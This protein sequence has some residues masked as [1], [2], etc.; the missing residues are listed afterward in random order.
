[1]RRAYAFFV[2]LLFCGAELPLAAQIG[3]PGQY[4][5][6]GRYPGGGY[7]PG[8]GAGTGI[9][10]PRRGKKT[11]SKDKDQPA[12]TKEIEG[13]LR[14]MDDKL[15]V[16]E[17]SDARIISIKRSSTTKFLKQ[18]EAMKPADLK[19]GDHLKIDVTEDEQGF[20]YAV[21]VNFD[22]AGTAAERARAAE[23]VE[24]IMPKSSDDDDRPVQKRAGSSAKASRDPDDPDRPVQKRAEPAAETAKVQPP[25]GAEPPAKTE[26]SKE[27]AAPKP[28]PAAKPAAKAPAAP[29]PPSDE[30]PALDTILKAPKPDTPTPR[31]T[32]DPGPPKLGR[33]RP[34]RRSTTP[35]TE[36]QQ[37]VQTATTRPPAPPVAKDAP[38][39][40]PDRNVEIARPSL[41]QQRAPQGE[42]HHDPVIEKA[43]EKAGEFTETLPSY[44]CQEMMARFYNVSHTVNWQPQDVVSMEVVYDQGKE[45]YRNIAVN[46][47]PSKKSMQELG[48]AWS[49]GEFGT[50]LIDLFSPATAADFRYRRGSVTAGKSTLVYD[51]DVQQP[52]SHWNIIGAAQSYKPAYRGTVWIDKQT[53]R[54]LRIE[55]QAYHFPEDFPFDKVES[56]T[57]YDYVRFAA[58]QQ[59]LMPVHAETLMCSRGTNQCSMNKID[60]RNYHK[61]AGESVISFGDAKEVPKDGAADATKDASKTKSTKKR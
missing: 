37:P 21:N 60:F 28:A 24:V 35:D 32:D 34:V 33:G 14:R 17:A 42:A 4:P 53:Y 18:D 8:G 22:K 2:F 44:V 7:P 41:P 16:L 13:M 23:P 27:T 12:P 20:F 52:N 29:E 3:Y 6:G 58:D 50:V 51:F 15:I 54:V 26:P 57:D 5:P 59:F 40:M 38:V 49:T 30:V 61:Y 36:P 9:P 55:M 45:S 46:S 1:M 10:M 31:D 56:A 25:A 47:K 48:G 43:R 11:T 39:E 19:P